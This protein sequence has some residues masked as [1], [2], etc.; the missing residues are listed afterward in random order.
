MKKLRILCLHGYHGTGEVLRRQ[1]QSL[2][3]GFESQVELVYLDAPSLS[4]GDYGWWHAVPVE[5]ART[6]DGSGAG[7][8]RMRYEGWERTRK[9]IV[10]AFDRQGPFD[11]VFG[12]SQGAALTGLVVG[13]RAPDGVP[14]L[15]QPITFDFAIL[16]SGFVSNDPAHASLYARKASYALPSLHLI[17]RSDGV[18]PTRDS[19][20]LAARFGEPTLVE[21]GG[22]HVVASDPSVRTAVG[23]FL[24]EMSRRST[25][26]REV[27]LWPGRERPSM[28]VFLP[29]RPRSVLA[30]ALLVLRG[31]AYST[32][33][34]SGGEAA[35]WL[36]SQGIAGIE[37]DYRTRGNG[38][39]YPASYDDAARAVRIV[40][41]RAKEWGIDP[42]RIGV[43]GFSAGGHLASLLSTQPS[44]HL[45]PEDDLA[46]SV[47][48][49]PDLVVLAYPLI[50]YVDGY[51]SGAFAGS[52]ENFFG[53][54]D[55]DEGLR[56]QFSNELHVE[57]THPPVFVW[58]TE[59]DGI[60]PFTHAKRFADACR[61]AGVPV[62]LT[63]YS[64]GPHGMGLALGAPSDASTWTTTLLEWLDRRWPATGAA[65]APGDV[66]W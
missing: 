25:A 43:M 3:D 13:L 27:P 54:R 66:P 46:G 10:S 21:H 45:A 55:P 28:R 19:R 58:T 24:Q 29:A 4:E 63:L 59:D 33:S 42:K 62:Q 5:S 30:P 1:M 61:A 22:G 9:A 18:V 60:V 57:A 51:R 38:E 40:R 39:A 23:A 32:S 20:E 6:G 50:S 41:R 44:L 64:H 49:R 56:R 52:T 17:G 11:G 14:T 15:E 16:V 35:E 47:S 26:P 48:A 53:R 36:A 12:F 8:A 7:H 34:G 31:G 65:G 2:M 37:V